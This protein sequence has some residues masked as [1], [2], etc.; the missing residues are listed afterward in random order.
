[1]FLT[2]Q[3]YHYDIIYEHEVA[4][5]APAV[6]AAEARHARRHALPAPRGP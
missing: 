4:D 2:E 6:L 1:L 5:F 3:G